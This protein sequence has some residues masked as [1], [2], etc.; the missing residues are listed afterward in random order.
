MVQQQQQ[1]EQMQQQMQVQQ[2][3]QQERPSSESQGDPYSTL[4]ISKG[5]ASQMV[6]EILYHKSDTVEKLREAIAM[7]CGVPAG[8][9]MKISSQAIPP[10]K[11]GFDLVS[12]FLNPDFPVIIVNPE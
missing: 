5:I 6:G 11:H 7:E 9:S 2:Q 4:Y 12:N 10:G 8:F 3:Q 1:Q